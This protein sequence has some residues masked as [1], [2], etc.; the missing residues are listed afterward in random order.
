MLR[1][2]AANVILIIPA[3]THTHTHYSFNHAF[4]KCVKGL[5]CVIGGGLSVW[6]LMNLPW[7]RGQVRIPRWWFASVVVSACVGLSTG[8]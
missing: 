5:C 7:G 3:H 6:G 4:A 1:C 8:R 2:L